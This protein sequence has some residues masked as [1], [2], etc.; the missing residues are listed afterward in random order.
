MKN[1]YKNNIY[2]NKIIRKVYNKIRKY[3]GGK[4]ASYIPELAKVNPEIFAISIVD[5]EGNIYNIGNYN[6]EVAI[7]SISK[8][9][10]LTKALEIKGKKQ[11]M[12]KI[13]FKGSSLAFNSIPAEELTDTHTINPFVNQGAIATTSLLYKKNKRSF[14]NMILNNMRTFANRNLKLGKSVYHS[15]LKS[16][17][18]NVA[19]ATILKSHNR[20]YG[21]INDTID[22]Y[23]KQCSMK[24]TSQDL[25]IMASVYANN[26]IHPQTKKRLVKS[27]HLDLILQAMKAEGLYQYSDTWMIRTNGVSAKSGV[28]G[29]ILMIIPGVCGIGIV[30]PPLDKNGNSYKGIETGV[31]LSN[32]IH[33]LTGKKNKDCL[34]NKTLKRKLK[35]KLKKK[36][37]KIYK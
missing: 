7:E 27:A 17:L 18:K 10:T 24:V 15:E 1:L 36:T 9:F 25:A 14:T 20:F 12:K 4:V 5:C 32:E 6:T 21:N 29:G 23:T 33:K 2:M 8:L 26:G 3:K 31:L 35:K 19:L 22:V 34:V 30:S 28:G 13:G 37:L 16:N 11:L